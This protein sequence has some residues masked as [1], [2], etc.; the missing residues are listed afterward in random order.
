MRA[1]GFGS[2][3]AIERTFRQVAAVRDGLMAWVANY[4]D[5]PEALDAAQRG[6]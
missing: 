2:G 5:R 1:A 6:K 3:V 4:T